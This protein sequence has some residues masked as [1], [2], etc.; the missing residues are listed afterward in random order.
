[1]NKAVVVVGLIGVAI[2]VVMIALT[3]Y[4]QSRAF[5]AGTPVVFPTTVFGARTVEDLT[6]A[7]LAGKN[8]DKAKTKELYESGRMAFISAGT[9][10]EVLE[11]R[12]RLA[13]VRII[14]PC[15]KCGEE[16]VRSAREVG[17]AV[18]GD[19][20]YVRTQFLQRGV[21]HTQ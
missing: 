15:L 13:R 11:Q 10:A 2:V 1:M 7:E 5:D 17:L 16:D 4:E 21:P 3:N 14:D 20:L 8:Y 18:D 19:R 9:R 6:L 12:G